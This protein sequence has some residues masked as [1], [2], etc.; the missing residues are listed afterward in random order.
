MVGIIRGFGVLSIIVAVMLFLVSF[1]FV[2]FLPTFLMLGASA[3]LSGA[4][5][6]AFARAV[7]LLEDLNNKL[8]PIHNIALVLEEKY[9]PVAAKSEKSDANSSFDPNNPIVDPMASLP[10][11]SR[12]ER[13]FGRRVAFL[14]DRSVMGETDEGLKKFENIA[15]WQR[16]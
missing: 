5:L 13:K 7:E 4:I 6:I 11:G 16:Y 8:V 14:P 10:A 12:I 9:R 3:L 2:F 15:D 1:V